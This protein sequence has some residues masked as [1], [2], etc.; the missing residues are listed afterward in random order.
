MLFHPTLALPP[1]LAWAHGWTGQGHDAIENKSSLLHS[2]VG[3]SWKS[4][5]WKRSRKIIWSN[6]SWKKELRWHYLAPFPVTSW[7]HPGMR[8][9]PCRWEGMI[10]LFCWWSGCMCPGPAMWMGLQKHVGTALWWCLIQVVLI[11]LLLSA[12]P[13]ICCMASGWYFNPISGFPVAQQG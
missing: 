13:W 9:P 12:L 5:G 10:S 2:E 11:L 6:L 8:T 3:F 7:K 4:P 1:A